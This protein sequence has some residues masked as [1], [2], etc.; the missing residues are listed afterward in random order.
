MELKKSPAFTLQN[1]EELR[2]SLKRCSPETVEAAIDFRHNANLDQLPV[3]VM[4]IIE[5]FLEPDVRHCLREGDDNTNLFEDLGVDSLLMVEIII[6]V[7]ETLDIS[8]ANDE[9]REIRTVGDIKTYL[10]YKVK[11]IP[12]PQRN[13]RLSIEDIASVMPH[14]DP[15]LFIRESIISLNEAESKY[16]ISGEEAFLDGHFKNNPVFPASILIE[17]LGQLAV[18]YLIKNEKPEFEQPVNPK[19]IMFYSSDGVRCHR[20]CRPG[21]ILNLKVKLKRIRY[22]LVTFEGT[23]TVGDEKAVFAEDITLTFDYES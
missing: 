3:I 13:K 4:G 12:I 5:R 17:A 23:I 22:P 19:T 15:F 8:I 14:Q 1:E 20:I 6:L 7:E 9:L 10:D 2:E 18:L 16:P 11:G 21:D